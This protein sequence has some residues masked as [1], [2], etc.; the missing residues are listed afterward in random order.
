MPGFPTIIR[1]LPVAD[2]PF[3]DIT[4]FLLRGPTASLTFVEAAADSEVP[5]HSHGPQ[6]GVVVAGELVLTIGKGTRTYRAGE[7][8][9]IPAGVPHAAKLRAGVRVIDFFDDPNRY[10]PKA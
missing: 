7:E 4:L 1:N 9:F 3:K 2:A 5:I 10:R 8:Y 6:W